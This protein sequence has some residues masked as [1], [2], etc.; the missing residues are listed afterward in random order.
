MVLYA[1]CVA[2][3]ENIHDTTMLYAT[4]VSCMIVFTS[5]TSPAQDHIFP[6]NLS[7]SNHKTTFGNEIN[8]FHVIEFHF[9]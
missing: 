1:I 4:V 9:N 8:L 2:E 7:L 6:I 5:I 3:N